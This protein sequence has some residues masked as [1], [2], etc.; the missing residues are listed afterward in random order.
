MTPK[1]FFMTEKMSLCSTYAHEFKFLY[2]SIFSNPQKMDFDLKCILEFFVKHVSNETVDD[3]LVSLNSKVTYISL[4]WT[5]KGVY[6]SELDVKIL[7]INDDEAHSMGIM[8]LNAEDYILFKDQ[9][10]NEFGTEFARRADFLFYLINFRCAKLPIGKKLLE[11]YNDEIEFDQRI[12]L[13]GS[14]FQIKNARL[15]RS[16]DEMSPADKANW[17]MFLEKDYW[18]S[19]DEYLDSW[20]D[21]IETEMRVVEWYW[22]HDGHVDT[23]IDINSWP[24][25]NEA[26]AI[27]LDSKIVLLNGDQDLNPVLP[28]DEKAKQF[29]D[30]SDIFQHIRSV[31]CDGQHEICQK[32][33]LLN[34]NLWA[35][36]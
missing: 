9:Q 27:I 5:N 3:Y 1:F 20:A 22:T 33:N 13:F 15:L 31:A 8:Y 34:D 18:Q 35:E 4:R 11:K 25:D 16:P 32:V 7:K 19:L 26:G 30:V 14:Q 23:L 21:G 28:L 12:K 10:I 29:V 6:P 2:L 17:N 36:H 24:G